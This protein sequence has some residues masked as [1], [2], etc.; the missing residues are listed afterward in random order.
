MSYMFRIAVGS[1]IITDAKVSQ[2][3]APQLAQA[4]AMPW[5]ADSSGSSKDNVRISLKKSEQASELSTPPTQKRR[6]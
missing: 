2:A 3:I 6:S 4:L 5:P 1:E